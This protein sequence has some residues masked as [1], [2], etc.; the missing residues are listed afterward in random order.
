M[1]D[2]VKMH[3][4]ISKHLDAMIEELDKY[5]FKLPANVNGVVKFKLKEGEY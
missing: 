1:E 2:K 4:I 3:L 5:G